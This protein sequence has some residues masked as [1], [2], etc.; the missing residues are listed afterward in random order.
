MIANVS[1]ALAGFAVA[2][3][4]AGGA[5]GS[6]AATGGAP[7]AS[8]APLPEGSYQVAANFC[9]W[10]AIFECSR[11]RG[12]IPGPGRVINTNNYPNFAPGYFCRVVGPFDTRIEALNSSE[13]G[14]V[15]NGGRGYVKRGC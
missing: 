11:S 9:G 15:Y 12:G 1:K 8:P 14:K 6:L 3:L 10:Y 5:S 13:R 2:A 4:I 7:A